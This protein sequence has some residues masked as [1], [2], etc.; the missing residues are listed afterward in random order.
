MALTKIT[1][2]VVA[3][4][5]LTAANIADNT[6]D[7]TKIAQNQI[8]ARHI[9]NATALTL[10]GGVTV[11]ELTIDGDTITA[12]DDF[13]ID[14]VGDITL[15]ADGGDI[16]FKDG[17]TQIGNL[18]NSSSDFVITSLVQ[19][20]DILIK[21][22]DGGSTITALTLDMSAAGKAT[23]NNAIV[24][25]ANST[26]QRND[27]TDYASTSE[28]AGILT[29]YNSNG[30]DGGGVNNYSSLEFNTGDGAT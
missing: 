11:D 21:G 14:A 7:A 18:S 10:D 8:L 28:P 4:N 25:Q 16:L 5:S 27:D 22:D 23:F 20:K 1:T 30:S 15:D 29:L 9:A 17:G 24:A 13:I 12:T 6:I 26:I 3:V 19:D 2:S